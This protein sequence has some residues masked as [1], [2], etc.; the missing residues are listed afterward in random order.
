MNLKA[1][2]ESLTYDE[3]VELLQL[4]SEE[5]VSTWTTMPPHIREAMQDKTDYNFT[6]KPK[7]NVTQHRRKEPVKSRGNEFID[8]GESRD[9]QTPNVNITPRTRKPPA[10]KEVMCHVCKKVNKVN[11]NLVYGEYYRCD[12][13]IRG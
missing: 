3:R 1:L 11:A 12:N 5:D 8:T 9:I 7:T 6:M 4:L 2:V 10:K 13:C